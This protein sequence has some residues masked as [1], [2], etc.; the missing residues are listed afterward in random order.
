MLRYE[1]CALDREEFYNQILEQIKMSLM[2]KPIRMF[3]FVS[4]AYTI[5]VTLADKMNNFQ[6]LSLAGLIYQFFNSLIKCCCARSF[7]LTQIRCFT[8][9]CQH[10]KHFVL[11]KLRFPYYI[12]LYILG[13]SRKTFAFGRNP[14]SKFFGFPFNFLKKIL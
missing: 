13:A 3:F 5:S 2:E 14:V 4:Q 10:Y 7:F 12:S 8:I 1:I 9:S 6:K 11:L